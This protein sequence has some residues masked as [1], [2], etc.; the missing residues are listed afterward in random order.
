MVDIEDLIVEIRLR[1]KYH[2]TIKAPGATLPRALV[3]DVT[4]LCDAVTQLIEMLDQEDA[5]YEIL[6]SL[7]ESKSAR[8]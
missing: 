2:E 8:H 4:N 6:E 5:G 3:A 7:D 1:I